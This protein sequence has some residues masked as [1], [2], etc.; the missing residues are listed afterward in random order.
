MEFFKSLIEEI[1][2]YTDSF[3]SVE[4]KVEEKEFVV[5]MK[6]LLFE[7][8]Q[9]SAK[10]QK[11]VFN[12]VVQFNEQEMLAKHSAF[13]ML[14]KRLWRVWFANFD[15]SVTQLYPYL[16]KF[17]ADDVLYQSSLEIFTLFPIIS[18]NDEYNLLLIEC[19]E[20]RVKEFAWHYEQIVT[21][22]K[23]V[24]DKPKEVKHSPREQ[25]KR[26]RDRTPSEKKGTGGRRLLESTLT[27]RQL[28]EQEEEA[29]DRGRRRFSEGKHHRDSGSKRLLGANKVIEEVEKESSYFS[30]DVQK[31]RPYLKKI[32]IEHEVIVS[33]RPRV[34]ANRGFYEDSEEGEVQSSNKK[35]AGSGGV[36]PEEISWEVRDERMPSE[37]GKQQKEQREGSEP[38]KPLRLQSEKMEAKVDGEP[39]E[40]WVK[41]LS[42]SSQ[43]DKNML[44]QKLSYSNQVGSFQNT[45]QKS[46]LKELEE[47]Q[48][49]LLGSKLWKLSS[50]IQDKL[51]QNI[52]ES[53]VDIQKY[54]Y[55]KQVLIEIKESVLR[56]M[57][58]PF[59]RN[60]I[61]RY[62]QCTYYYLLM[63]TL[64]KAFV[65]LKPQKDL[66]QLAP[67]RNSEKGEKKPVDNKS[68]K[69]NEAEWEVNN[70]AIAVPSNKDEKSNKVNSISIQAIEYSDEQDLSSIKTEELKDLR[71][72]YGLERGFDSKSRNGI[73]NGYSSVKGPNHV[74]NS[75]LR[76]KSP[77]GK[78]LEVE[79]PKGK[80]AEMQTETREKTKIKDE[81]IQTRS[82]M[83]TNQI[84]QVPS[85]SSRIQSRKETIKEFDVP[86]EI[87]ENKERNI[88]LKLVVKRAEKKYQRLLHHFLEKIV[89]QTRQMPM[90]TIPGTPK[91]ERTNTSE[92]R[93]EKTILTK[94]KDGEEAA[95]EEQCTAGK[96]SN[97]YFELIEG[98]DGS[99]SRSN[100]VSAGRDKS[101]EGLRIPESFAERRDT[102]P[103]FL[104]VSRQEMFEDNKKAS[105]VRSPRILP[106]DKKLV[107]KSKEISSANYPRS[108]RKSVNDYMK[109]LPGPQSKGKENGITFSNL[110]PI[111]QNGSRFSPES[112]YL[113]CS[114]RKDKHQRSE[115]SCNSEKSD[116]TVKFKPHV[117]ST[118][119]ANP[120]L[121]SFE[122]ASV[123]PN[124]DHTFVDLTSKTER[125]TEWSPIRVPMYDRRLI[126]QQLN[127]IQ[128]KVQRKI[129]QRY[130]Q[131][132]DGIEEK[133][134]S[135]SPNLRK[136]ALGPTD[137]PAGQRGYLASSKS[138]I[139]S[140]RSNT[141]NRLLNNSK[142]SLN[143]AKKARN[144][145]RLLENKRMKEEELVKRLPKR[146]QKSF[147]T[148]KSR[149]ANKGTQPGTKSKYLEVLDGMRGVSPRA[150]E[151]SKKG[152]CTWEKVRDAT[153]V[154]P[155][156]M[157][158]H[159]RKQRKQVPN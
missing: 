17:L 97:H 13:E 77:K 57:M 152:Q 66:K 46:K 138:P 131:H 28:E 151:K 27:D 96:E 101:K 146:C 82:V 159:A 135:V 134:R 156:Q 93:K 145:S 34:E 80:N 48:Q 63:K 2:Y 112:G 29:E 6:E 64:R 137:K 49:R 39:G 130:R 47:Q 50:L 140:S 103:V 153:R 71:D 59:A 1:E 10:Q 73:P 31:Q 92:S 108:G 35:G 132:L 45:N 23:F 117:P 98:S 69:K 62:P 19:L 148:E 119:A 125:Q 87:T 43:E 56:S 33:D 41:Q 81:S 126:R 157:L 107:E 141:P 51:E 52:R 90:K 42:L 58:S 120:S 85:Q 78:K 9:R 21:M 18:F 22:Y 36:Q 116:T 88:Y 4:F 84:V 110:K 53:Y 44:S 76:T 55:F 99:R 105:K 5:L 30:F 109:A 15:A 61:S 127:I 37:E 25:I 24:V 118:L 67:S 86:K 75:H 94:P 70:I 38:N 16:L 102:K 68:L 111:V 83:Q 115:I 154:S 3:D 8:L 149:E 144:K 133:K 11:G 20:D 136:E 122:Q 72:K 74:S 124:N 65:S 32:V 79:V 26:G 128:E 60:A 14:A 114:K 95:E 91:P 89:S 40:K 143:T 158:S 12:A 150:P 100:S 129:E 104:D 121:T 113:N 142:G 155:D 106:K 147:F 54:A 7:M 123:K 139:A